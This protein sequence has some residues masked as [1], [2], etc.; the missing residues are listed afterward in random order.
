MKQ[1]ASGILGILPDGN[2]QG[3]NSDSLIL[4]SSISAVAEKVPGTYVEEMN[5]L[6]FDQRL[7]G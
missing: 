7:E 4:N 5:H 3:I 6:A 1:R 2:V